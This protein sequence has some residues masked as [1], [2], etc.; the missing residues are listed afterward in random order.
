MTFES[1]V[2]KHYRNNKVKEEIKRYAVGRWVGL[3]CTERGS[4]RPYLIRYHWRGGK[5]LKISEPEEIDKLLKRF[6]KLRP[7]TF[8]A[9]SNVYGRLNAKEDVMDLNNVIACTPTWDIDNE[10]ESW[11]ATI[12]V[13]KEILSFLKSMGVEESTYVKWSG[14]GCHVHL[15]EESI[16]RELRV[17]HNPLDLAYT[18]VEY[19]NVKLEKRY[20]DVAEKN[21]AYK[22]RVENNIDPQRLFT[23]PLSLHKSLNKVC[24]CVDKDDLDEFNPEWTEIDRYK[25]FEGWNEY[26]SGE[27]DK[28]ALRAFETIGPCTTHQRFRRR[29]H[30]PLDRQISDWL[31]KT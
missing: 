13:A 30:P 9:T 1:I 11:E 16:S 17:K 10:L 8:Y 19:V 4:G 12:E 28:L 18:I 5:P 25:H 14:R 23:C 21:S 29:R 7:R 27:A 2:E 24:V 31:K 6:R 26:I 22:L 15:H 20:V 3:Y